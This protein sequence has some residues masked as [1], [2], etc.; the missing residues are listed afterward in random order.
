[1]NKTAQLARLRHY[2]TRY[3]VVAEHTTDRRRVLICYTS[4]H[5][6]RG[7]RRAITDNGHR[8]IDGLGLSQD[9]ALYPNTPA[10]AGFRLESWHVA[11]SG[12]T[13][14][15]AII[16]GELPFVGDLATSAA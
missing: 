1:M 14:R 9:A 15:E 12:R 10:S 13:Q 3:E 8:V 16:A 2:A 11:F 4:S 7:M 6:Q 5:S